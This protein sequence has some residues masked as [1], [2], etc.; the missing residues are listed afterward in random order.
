[1]LSF[2]NLAYTSHVG[3]ASMGQLLTLGVLLTLIGCLVVLPAFLYREH[4]AV[5]EIPT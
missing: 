1:M 3:V 5:P 4:E 2:S